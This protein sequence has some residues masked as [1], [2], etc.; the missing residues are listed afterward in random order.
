MMIK[1]CHNS[2]SAIYDDEGENWI[3]IGTNGETVWPKK[4]H[5]YLPLSGVLKYDMIPDNKKIL[6]E[7]REK[8]MAEMDAAE[9]E[10]N[11]TGEDEGTK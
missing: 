11:E 4:E 6:D 10:G 9:E 7:L 2:K 8:C 5:T 3:W 1:V